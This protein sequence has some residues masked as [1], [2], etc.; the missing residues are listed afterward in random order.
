MEW[1]AEDVEALNLNEVNEFESAIAVLLYNTMKRES[2]SIAGLLPDQQVLATDLHVK[3]VTKKGT[4]FDLNAIVDVL[5]VAEAGISDMASVLIRLS[6]RENVDEM[7]LDDIYEIFGGTADSVTLNYKSLD[8]PATMLWEIEEHA[9][10]N[11]K[12]DKILIL[13]CALLCAALVLVTSVLLYVAG[14]WRE[15]RERMEEQMDWFKQHR[16]YSNDEEDEESGNVD[17]A[18]SQS[19]GE[20]DA[21]EEATNPSGIIGASSKEENAAEGLGI[22]RTPERGNDDDAYST[23]PFSEMTNFTD[24]SR[25][26]LG[27]SSMRKMQQTGSRNDNM[28]SLP[29]LAYQ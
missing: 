11:Q 14:G 6:R 4:S 15:L 21:D 16:T 12:A 5:Y 18:D 19:Y 8:P 7:L 26:P 1:V 23:T 28:L 13:A 20:D 25:A 3:N 29:P 10:S 24:T 22:N 2:G 17:V 27:I 9:H